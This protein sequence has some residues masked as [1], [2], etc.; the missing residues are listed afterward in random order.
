MYIPQHFVQRAAAPCPARNARDAESTVIITAILHLDKRACAQMRAR[1]RLASDRFQVKGFFRQIQQIGDQAVLYIILDHP[2]DPWQ[3]LRAAL[4]QG[5]PTAGDNDF[6]GLQLVP[7]RRPRGLAN[8][9]ARIRCSLRSHRAG[10]DHHIICL[11]SA[12]DNLMPGCPELAGELF[13]L[14][15]VQAAA[16]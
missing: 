13:N 7:A 6:T 3:R 2:G 1:Q 12:I 16:D 5:C 8:F 11:G 14:A 10:I 15:L 9:L 4:I